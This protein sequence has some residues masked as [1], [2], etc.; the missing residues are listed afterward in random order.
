[1]ARIRMLTRC[2]RLVGLLRPLTGQSVETLAAA[3]GVST[4]TV[5]RDLDA[6][7]AAGVP[8]QRERVGFQQ[9]VHVRLQWG[10]ACPVCGRGPMRR[11]S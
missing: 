9:A 7:E 11:A 8:V 1:M 6:L 4:R 10:A 2:L 5:R 3:V